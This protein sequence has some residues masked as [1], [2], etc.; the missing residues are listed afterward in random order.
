MYVAEKGK[1]LPKEGTYY[2]VAKDKFF[3]HK[4]TGIVKALVEID[5]IGALDDLEPYVQLRLP[6]LPP[7]IIYRAWKFFNG[8]VKRYRSESAVVLHY[9]PE[10]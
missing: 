4:D 1:E 10:T 7:D 2:V 8:V 5:A 9:N 6:K 3:L